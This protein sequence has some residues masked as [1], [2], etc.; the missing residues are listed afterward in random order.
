MTEAFVRR[1]STRRVL[2]EAWPAFT[3]MG[4]AV[5]VLVLAGFFTVRGCSGDGDRGHID[6]ARELIL[7]QM[8]EDRIQNDLRLGA[9][10]DEINEMRNELWLIDQEIAASAAIREDIHE[11]IENAGSIDAIDLAI[12]A[13]DRALEAGRTGGNRRDSGAGKGR[14]KGDAGNTGRRAGGVRTEANRR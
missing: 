11:A 2:R 12:G 10:Q 5:A 13:I 6:A 7:K 9:L 14:A 1:L 4:L 8:T 3:L